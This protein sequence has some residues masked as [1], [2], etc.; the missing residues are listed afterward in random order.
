M[1]SFVLITNGGPHA[2]T[3]WSE[4]SIDQLIKVVPGAASA[5][6]AFKAKA[7]EALTAV[8]AAAQN[9]ERFALDADGDGR[10]GSPLDP[11]EYVD[12][13]F[14][15]VLG[16]AKGTPWEPQIAATEAVWRLEIG[17]RITSIMDIERTCHA[18]RQQSDLGK[19]WLAIRAAQGAK[20]ACKACAGGKTSK[21]HW[22]PEAALA[23]QKRQDAVKTRTGTA[24]PK[25]K[26][27]KKR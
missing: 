26:T 6:Y 17:T 22:T 3:K 27:K 20:K 4:V 10:L 24:K 9:R 1:Q 16:A 23:E 18:G 12:D 25:R 5:A 8:Y 2:A 15:A 21:T 19:R 11:G 14:A 13:G 7:I